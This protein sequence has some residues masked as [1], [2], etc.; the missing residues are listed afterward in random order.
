MNIK[1]NL[2]RIWSVVAVLSLA[3]LIYLWL[4]ETDSPQL[5][6]TLLALDAVMFLLALP[7]GVFGAGVVLAAWY[8]L[9][10]NPTSIEGA[11]LN[12]IVLFLLGTV[13]WFWLIRFYYPPE[14][15]F[16]KLNLTEV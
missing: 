13:Q 8:V 4:G 16:Q 11:Y 12:T 3:L 15:P 14:T 7:C 1:T 6:N 10:M 5:L 2:K 9:G